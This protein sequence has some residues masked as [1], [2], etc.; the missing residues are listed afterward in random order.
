VV[1][2]DAMGNMDFSRV[3]TNEIGAWDRRAIVYG[4]SDFG[5]TG[6]ETA[7][8]NRILE[9]TQRQGLLYIADADARAADGMHPQAHLWDNGKSPVEELRRMLRVRERALSRFSE[10][11]IRQNVPMSRLEDALVPIYNYHRYQLEAVCKLVGGM[12]YSYAVRGDRQQTPRVLDPSVQNAAL[13]AAL[14]CL[15]PKV[16]VLPENVLKII[17]P[18]PPQYYNIGELM[19]KRMGMSLDVLAAAEALVHYEFGFL[20]HPNRAN[21]LVQQKATDGRNIGFDNV[22]NSLMERYWSNS[23]PSGLEGEL[24][25]QTR[26]IFVTHLL[27]LVQSEATNYS[28]KSMCFRTLDAIKAT[29]KNTNDANQKAHCDYIIHRIDN[30]KDVQLPQHKELPPGAPIGCSDGDH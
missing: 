9:E 30:P 26:Q 16:L 10:N 28:V 14:D 1:N 24:V 18:R 12:D 11:V 27:G 23:V 21:R 4:Y 29:C 25:L 2:L 7:D 22:L 17:P 8:L 20:L 3:Y 5:K 15:D 13:A 6:D 19:P